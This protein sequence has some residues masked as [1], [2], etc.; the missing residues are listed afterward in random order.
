M[1]D[2]LTSPTQCCLPGKLI[3]PALHLRLFGIALPVRVE[4]RL[5]F[6]KFCLKLVEM[7]EGGIAF[8]LE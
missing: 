3:R 2:Q 7:C 5:K 6:G 4:F 8:C 1:A